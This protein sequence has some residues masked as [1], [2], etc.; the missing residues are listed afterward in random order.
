MNSLTVYAF[1]FLIG[2]ITGLRSMTGVAA[3][4][5]AARFGWLRLQSTWL[6]FMGNSIPP[7][8]LSV[9]ALG[10]LVGD[11]LPNAPSR[12]SPGPFAG[13]VLIGGFAGAAL[14]TG[15]GNAAVLGALAG[16]MGGI[17]GTL[18]GYEA[19]VRSVKALGVPDFV[20]ALIEDVIA[21]GG[22]FF[23]VSRFD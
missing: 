14:A 6:S 9:L 18:G 4:C 20:V 22:A 8:I 2:A 16:A 17:C 5:W 12:K 23:I 7:Y 19:R 1:A 21:V 11:K 15:S 3:V 10:E 13:R